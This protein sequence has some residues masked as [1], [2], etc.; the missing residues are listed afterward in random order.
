MSSS[1]SP[2][3]ENVLR[4]ASC[5]QLILD[6][7]NHFILRLSRLGQWRPFAA[8]DAGGLVHN[9]HEIASHSS[10]NLNFDVFGF[11][12]ERRMRPTAQAQLPLAG[13]DGA[14]GDVC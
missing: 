10:A 1:G 5:N 8:T 13:A 9:P 14:A 3:G 6:F 2:V 4:Q 11:Q 7:V 12:H